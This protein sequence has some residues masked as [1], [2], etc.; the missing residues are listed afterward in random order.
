MAYI[1]VLTKTFDIARKRRS[2]ICVRH[3]IA[4]LAILAAF[5]DFFANPKLIFHTF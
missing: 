1:G 3:E 2:Y 5:R 4:S